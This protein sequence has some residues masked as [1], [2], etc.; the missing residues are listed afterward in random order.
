MA[1]EALTNNSLYLQFSFAKNFIGRQIDVGFQNHY[2][3][4]LY[5]PIQYPEGI[6]TAPPSIIDKSKVLPP[7]NRLPA[8][9]IC[10]GSDFS[11]F[12]RFYSLAI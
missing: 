5:K 3:T 1:S 10:V 9:I 11:K 8:V 4:G 2:C 7:V 6:L 12:S